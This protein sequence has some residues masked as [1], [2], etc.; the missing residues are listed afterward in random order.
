M[1]FVDSFAC[2]LGRH[3]PRRGTVRWDRDAMMRVGE[4]RACDQRI[5]RLGHR[6]W[7]PMAQIPDAKHPHGRNMIAEQMLGRHSG[8][9][10]P[11]P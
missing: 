3:R 2:A 11:K 5:G 10:G 1:S 6:K 4:C 9:D 7:K 8:R